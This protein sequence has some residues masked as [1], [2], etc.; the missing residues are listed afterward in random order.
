MRS[1]RSTTLGTCRSSFD[2]WARKKNRETRACWIAHT[3]GIP[4]HRARHT[5]NGAFA[6]C[7]PPPRA[8]FPGVLAVLAVVLATGCSSAAGSSESGTVEA[9]TTGDAGTKADSGTKSDAGLAL[10]CDIRDYG[11]KADGKTVNTKGHPGGH[12]RVRASR[13]RGAHPGRH[14]PERHDRPEGQHDLPRPRRRHPARRRGEGSRRQRAAGR[15]RGRAVLPRPQ[16]LAVD[17]QLADQQHPASARVRAGG[18]QP[19][20][21]RH[22]HHRRRRRGS[23]LA[24]TAGLQGRRDP[25]PERD[26]PPAERS[27]HRRRHHPRELG[28][29]D[30]GQHGA[31]QPVDLRHHRRLRDRPHARRD[32]RSS[33]AST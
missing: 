20:H 21:H 31:D 18:D 9:V 3:W 23:H 12:R 17:Q 4:L 32:R 14:V 30:D 7:L 1:A 33:T 6:R 26:V 15:H 16:A 28:D 8:P 11:A 13:R 22:R 29:V 25:P 2:R 10:S 24:G 19:A 27:R 5:Y